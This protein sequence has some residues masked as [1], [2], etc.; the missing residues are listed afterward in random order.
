MFRLAFGSLAENVNG[1]K[2][3]T[4]FDNN[5]ECTLLESTPKLT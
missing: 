5:L 1:R 4:R 2:K 3:K